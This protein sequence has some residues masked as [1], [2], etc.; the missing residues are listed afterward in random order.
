MTRRKVTDTGIVIPKI[1]P[2]LGPFAA[3]AIW[4]S[5]IDARQAITPERHAVNLVRWNTEPR[6]RR[7]PHREGVIKRLVHRI[8]ILSLEACYIAFVPFLHIAVDMN[9]SPSPS[10]ISMQVSDRWRSTTG[11]GFDD[12]LHFPFVGY[13]TKAPSSVLSLGGGKG[14]TPSHHQ[15]KLPTSSKSTH[16]NNTSDFERSGRNIPN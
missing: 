9:E 15:A 1:N 12:L 5:H 14:F 2:R 6:H 7:M 4:L 10:S 8:A 16:L 11:G 13:L 3:F